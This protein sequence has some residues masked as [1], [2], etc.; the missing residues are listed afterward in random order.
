MEINYKIMKLVNMLALLEVATA[1]QKI[2]LEKRIEDYR[3]ILTK[4]QRLE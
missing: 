2:H 1:E 4:K 3:L